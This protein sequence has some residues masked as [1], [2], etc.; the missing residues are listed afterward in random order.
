MITRMA[1][2]SY[3]TILRYYWMQARKH[4]RWMFFVLVMYAIGVIFADILNP[5]L[6]RNIIDLVSGAT[7]RAATWPSI[8]MYLGLLA[9]SMII[10]QT[11]YRLGDFAIVRF[12]YKVMKDLVDFAFAKL[13]AHSYKFFT[14][15]FAGSLVTKVKRFVRSFEDGF[16]QIAFVFWMTSVQIVGVMVSL[17]LIARPIAW[18]FLIW[19]VMYLFLAIFL[20]KKKIP[21]DLK[22]STTDSKVTARLA[23]VITNILNV[24]M[25]SSRSDEIASFED[26]TTDE[27]KARHN[28]WV[29]GNRINLVQSVLFAILEFLGISLTLYLWK[30]GSISVGTIVIVQFY[31]GAM[32]HNLW[33]IGKAMGRISKSF[34]DASELVEIFETPIGITD[35]QQPEEVRITRGEITLDKMS[36]R[37]GKDAKRV[38]KDFSLTIPSGQRVGLVGHSGAGKTTIT[39]LLLRF[40][41]VDSGTITIDGQDIR[42][43]TQDD[44]R[45]KISYVPQD[46]ILFHRSLRENIAY[47]NPGATEDEILAASKKAHAHE[48]IV[49]LNKGYETLVG[50]RGIKLSGGERQRVAIARA[51]LKNAPILILDEATSSLDSISEKYIQDALRILM[52]NRTTIVIAHRLSTVQGLDRIIVI[53]RGAI[54]EDGTH[55]ELLKKSDGVYADFWEHQTSGFIE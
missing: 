44:L 31:I 28:A 53:K 34:A 38:F 6:Y 12:E 5:I 19:I 21:Y 4:H 27:Q 33:N 40:A 41:D 45:S 23:D 30:Q 1:Q 39:K 25:F 32:F 29:F 55:S 54:A 43:I 52:K 22:E 51:M 11:A 17:F 10:F 14:N 15:S 2:P 24:K 47:G 49:K 26:V 50:E 18:L 36:F 13:T 8:L 48:F 37:Y 7:D 20:N 35:P 9:G 46:P 16:D 42:D 3:R